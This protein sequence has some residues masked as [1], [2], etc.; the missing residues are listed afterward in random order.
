[1]GLDLGD[2]GKGSSVGAEGDICEVFPGRSGTPDCRVLSVVVPGL[3]PGLVGGLV[4]G[5]EV[6]PVADGSMGTGD[7]EDI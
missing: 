3:V 1:M 5:I 6:N 4:A 7:K 2:C